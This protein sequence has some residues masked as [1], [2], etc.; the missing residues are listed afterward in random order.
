MASK[1]KHV[2]LV[3]LDGWGIAPPSPGNAISQ[4]NTPNINY[5]ETHYPSLLLQA[6]GKT[7]GLPWGNEGNSEVGHLSL[8]S[9]RIIF[10]YLPRIV[11]AI[12]D[13]S[14]FKNKTLKSVSE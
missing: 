1:I 9:G 2:I 10:H 6:S 8:G 12:Q 14:F 11:N 13:G 5:I 7:V 4:A 3:V